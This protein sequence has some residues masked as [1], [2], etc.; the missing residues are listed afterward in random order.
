MRYLTLA[1]IALV[2]TGCGWPV[3]AEPVYDRV[4]GATLRLEV[5]GGICSG[6]AVSRDWA[7]SA[8][9]CF[10]GGKPK[11]IRVN[12]ELCEVHAL[13]NDGNDHALI[14]LGGCPFKAWAK[15]GKPAKVG[16]KVFLWSNP[17]RFEN[18]LVFGTV[19]GYHPGDLVK[20]RMTLYDLN[21][22]YGS[23][24][25]A[26]FNERGEITAVLSIGTRPYVLMGSY[27][28]AFTRKQ[29]DEAL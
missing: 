2:G 27:P 16:D 1:L 11:T 22:Y 25:G 28:I 29:W 14:R 17:F 24:G 8:S 19:A 15:V 18:I 7:L 4:H 21:G 20:A 10:E 12:G 9:H 26:L 6:T 5:P 3:S 23:S 13:V